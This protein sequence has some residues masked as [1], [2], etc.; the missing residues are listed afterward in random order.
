MPATSA[1]GEGGREGSRSVA[2]MGVDP[3]QR[4]EYT[5]GGT[6]RTEAQRLCKDEL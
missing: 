4:S 2:A 1:V 5:A 6:E 3:T